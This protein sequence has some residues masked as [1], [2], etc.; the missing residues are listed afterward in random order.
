MHLQ[1]QKE[2]QHRPN[3][4]TAN[5]S[6]G[7]SKLALQTK[8]DKSGRKGSRNS[9]CYLEIAVIAKLIMVDGSNAD[10]QLG[11]DL[12]LQELHLIRNLQII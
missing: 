3:D 6:H 11:L 5:W 10:W 7:F 8:R 9:H 12:S 2:H 1:S 4:P